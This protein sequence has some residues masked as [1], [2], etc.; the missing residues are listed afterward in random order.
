MHKRAL[1]LIAIVLVASTAPAALAQEGDASAYA[2]STLS[3]EAN[4]TG[5]VDYAVGGETV[6]ESIRVNSQSE[7]ESGLSLG[8]SVD[9]G[10]IAGLEGS[11][12]SVGSTTETSATIRADSGA[13]IRAHDNG[14]GSLV[15]SSDGEPQYV[16]IGLNE[17]ASVESAGD[18]RVVVTTADGTKATVLATGDG[19]VSVNDDGNV[20]AAVEGESRVVMRAYA[21]GRS[22]ADAKT[23]DLIANGTAA[24]SVYLTGDGTDTVTYDGETAVEVTRRAEGTVE[25]TVDRSSHDGTVV[26]TSVAESTFES[27]EDVEV[28][29]DGSAAARASSY[30]ELES[31]ANG[32]ETSKYMVQGGSSASASADVLVAVN[33]FSARDI[34][35]SSG[36]DSADGD[37]GTDATESTDDGT[38]VGG[39]DGDAGDGSA[40]ATTADGDQA[41][42]PGGSGPGFGV[43]LALGAFV[44]LLVGVGRWRG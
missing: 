32:G 43:V 1:G 33:H 12:I 37:A 30:A 39:G 5:L 22:D 14:H 41:T 35:L 36:G 23:E 17:D 19:A 13:T 6:A 31:A 3:F 8:T 18:G 26:V 10:A 16:E 24:A 20:T 4:G 44:A 2:G 38:E 34:T 42:T 25:M 9:L 15:V 21:D 27:A 7:A 28:S 11:A 40:T 29:V